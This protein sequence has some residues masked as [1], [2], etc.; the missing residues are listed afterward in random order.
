LLHCVEARPVDI[1]FQNVAVPAAFDEN[2][3]TDPCAGN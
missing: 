1:R 3:L 2:L